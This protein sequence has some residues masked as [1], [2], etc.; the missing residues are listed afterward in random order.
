MFILCSNSNATAD[1]ASR[2]N[3]FHGFM[4]KTKNAAMIQL[5]HG[6]I[7]SHRIVIAIKNLLAENLKFHQL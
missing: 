5:V 2:N 4:Q 3:S 6:F 7:K 1:H